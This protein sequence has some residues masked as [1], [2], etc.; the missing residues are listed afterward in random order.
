MGAW[1]TSLKQ[2]LGWLPTERKIRVLILG[3]DNAGKTSIL[4]RLHLGD[5]VST[6]PTVGFNLETLEYKNLSFEVWDLGGQTGIR[7]YWRCYFNDTDAI[8]YVVDST[9]R[10]RL[11]VAKH[12]LY[13]LLDEDELRKSLLLIFA[14][15]QDLPDA[16]DEAYIAQQLG[17]TSTPNR[18]W[19]IVKSSAKTGDGL[20]EGMDWLVEKL[21]E[22]GLTA[23]NGK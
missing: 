16:A 17:I 14:N 10:D 19:T 5:V 1:L 21:R 23:T 7:P 18:T 22:E 20:I 11:G 2:T 6:V 9:D 13:A 15:K 3:L 12:E 8:I 4:Y